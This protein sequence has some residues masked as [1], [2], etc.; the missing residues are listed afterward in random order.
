M[1][2]LICLTTIA[3]SCRST[4]DI[5]TEVRTEYIHDTTEV[6]LVD[7]VKIVEVKRD[8]VDRY[9]EKTTYVD[10]NG[11][12]HEKEVEH[13]THYIHEQDFEYKVR[14]AGY[15]ARIATLEKQLSEKAKVEYVE[16]NLN[17]FQ[18]ALMRLGVGFVIV[19][20]GGAIAG[21][22]YIKDKKR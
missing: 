4:K 18:K 9:V 14:E 17:W 20:L 16:K 21:Y 10:T 13:L 15:K 22:F 2:A 19:M 3:T 1:V 11:V 5:Q 12:W 8:S 7:T 6:V